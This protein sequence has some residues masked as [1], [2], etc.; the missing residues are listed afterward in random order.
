M[1]KD[2]NQLDD[3]FR[4]KLDDFEQ[5]P[6]AYVWSRIQEQQA[7]NKRRMLF[8]YLKGAGVAAAVL[9]AF[10]LGWQLQQQPE[11]LAPVLTDHQVQSDEKTSQSESS[12]SAT[13]TKEG[14]LPIQESTSAEQSSGLAFAESGR[15][16]SAAEKPETIDS[17]NTIEFQI[18]ANADASSHGRQLD[19]ED[20]ENR[21]Q[22]TQQFQLLRLLHLELDDS[23]KEQAQLADLRRK[24]RETATQ[25]NTF[26]QNQI[27]ENA[28]LLAANRMSE[29]PAGWQL[30]AMLTPGVSVNQSSQSQNYASSMA[31]PDSKDKLQVGGGISIEYKTHKRW[32]VQSGVYYSK[33]GQT[34]SNQSFQ[35]E[36]LYSDVVSDGALR[37]EV[38]YFNTAVAV[39]SGEMLMNTAAGVVAIDRLPT[40]ARLSSGFETL[41]A[42]D[43]ILL[44][45]TE[46]E[47]QFEYIEIPLILRYQLID[48][49]FELQVLGGLNTSV[50]V[51]NNAYA[52]SEYGNERIGETRDMNAV[53]YSTSFG[54]GLGYGLSNKI[55]LHVEPQLRYFM[56]SLNSNSNVSFKPYTIG[57]YTG[58]SYQF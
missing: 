14:T 22:E 12:D 23:F 42:D 3:L 29:S 17:N 21:K 54:F 40:N 47:Q 53:N 9:L 51:G 58:L 39:K 33:L 37:G 43:G 4:S 15:G 35:P 28:R 26:E 41:A 2:N 50:L 24:Q 27:E 31:I 1:I 5:E 25:F 30:G 18:T 19:T 55:S 57:V 56:G 6:P 34:S 49:T 46:F 32:S 38:A 20:S 10:L 13:D 8:F 52:N 44:T 16:K 7:G 48:A 36:A 11:N 45:Q